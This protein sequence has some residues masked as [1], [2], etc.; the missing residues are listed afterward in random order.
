MLPSLNGDQ[1]VCQGPPINASHSAYRRVLLVTAANSV[2]QVVV[3]P[4]ADALT[5][6]TADCPAVAVNEPGLLR[7]A[8]AAQRNGIGSL[9]S[10]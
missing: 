1:Q 4:G 5:G 8:M 9:R 10:G 3:Q 2:L 6:S 7:R